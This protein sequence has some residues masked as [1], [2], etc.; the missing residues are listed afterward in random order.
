VYVPGFP[1]NVGAIND[2]ERTAGRHVDM[3]MW[4]VHWG[5][6]WSSFNAGDVRAVIARGSVPLIT[7]MS[8]DPSAPG[9]P[10]PR[11][12]RA[13]SAQGIL[14][15]RFDSYIRSWANGLRD[16]GRT[17]L[18]RFDHE[19]NGNWYAWSPGVNGQTAQDFVAAWRHVH[20]IFTAAGAT[21]VQWV[22]SPNVAFA[23]S[24]PLASLYPG[25]AYV[26][27]VGIDGYTWGAS[28]RA[29]TW[30]SFAA[31]F[32]AT[33]TQLAAVTRRPTMICEVASAEVG[34]NKAAWI[35]DFFS[36]LERRP[37]ISGFVWFNADKETDWRL[38]SSPSARSA[39]LAGLAGVS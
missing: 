5:G 20:D 26:D 21:N 23:G 29:H 19:M 16:V 15:G 25:D 39:F 17:V 4:Y 7:W 6:P 13:H 33:Q 34:G 12:Q 37:A 9:Y 30:Q 36:E 3:V 1:G 11:T 31:V 22:W 8:D 32:D 35:Q 14:A 10:D 2:V 38:D 27:R 18:L 28:D 24:A